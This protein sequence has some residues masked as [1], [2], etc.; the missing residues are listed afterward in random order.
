MRN[1]GIFQGFMSGARVSNQPTYTP[2]Y[3]RA[4]GKSIPQMIKVPIC[5]ND[6]KNKETGIAAAN[7]YTLVGWGK[8][9]D[10]LAK[11]CTKGRAIDCTVRP[12]SFKGDYYVGGVKL[13][14]PNGM[15]VQ[16]SRIGF[17]ILDI[18]LGEEAYEL[19]DADIREGRRAQDWYVKNS[20]GAASWQASL[21]SRSAAQYT[22]GPEFGYAKVQLHTG[23]SLPNQQG[24]VS[25]PQQVA[26]VLN[27]AQPA[28]MYV[29]N[30]AV[31]TPVAQPVANTVVNPQALFG[32]GGFGGT[33][34]PA[35]SVLST[36]GN[37]GY[38]GFGTPNGNDDDIP[39]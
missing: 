21:I 26:N 38:G 31:N 1:A 11:N 12:G 13:I 17:T 16:I 14:A 28:P 18:V 22:G 39:F 32:G 36:F 35:M 5:V 25:L 9:A 2:S 8:L 3:I 37:G 19:I 27:N 10:Y 7:F 23:M 24:Q 15:P 34:A 6:K 30:K 33:H 20:P 4:D 29:S